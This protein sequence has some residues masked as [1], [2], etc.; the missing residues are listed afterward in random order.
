VLRKLQ[1]DFFN[2]Y[3]QQITGTCNSLEHYG[4]FR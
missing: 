1:T 3:L 2:M 4:F